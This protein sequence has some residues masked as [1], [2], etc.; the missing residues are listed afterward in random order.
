MDGSDRFDQIVSIF[1]SD[2]LARALI[3]HIPHQERNYVLEKAVKNLLPEPD[4]DQDPSLHRAWATA[5][6]ELRKLAQ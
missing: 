4:R 1:V 6:E 2:A 3:G 5:L